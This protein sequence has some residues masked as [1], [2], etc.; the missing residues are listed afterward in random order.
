LLLMPTTEV[1]VAD[2]KEDEE[3]AAAWAGC[4]EKL[5]VPCEDGNGSSP[6]CRAV[7]FAHPARADLHKY[8]KA[9]ALRPQPIGGRQHTGDAVCARSQGP[10]TLRTGI[11]TAQMIA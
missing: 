5:Q 10:H 9:L 1:L 4:T 8:I 11:G 3:M 6:V 2:I 7:D